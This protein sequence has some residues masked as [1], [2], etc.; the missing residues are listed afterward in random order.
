[1]A[2]VAGLALSSEVENGIIEEIPD[3]KVPVNI[4]YLKMDIY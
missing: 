2:A 4:H 3:M 1:M